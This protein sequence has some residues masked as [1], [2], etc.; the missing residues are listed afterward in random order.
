MRKSRFVVL[1]SF[2]LIAAML[3]PGCK[4][5]EKPIEI[6]TFPDVKLPSLAEYLYSG[7]EEQTVL[8]E[9]KEISAKSYVATAE[10]TVAAGDS[11]DSYNGALFGLRC[12][13]ATDGREDSGIWFAFCGGQGSVYV[14]DGVD[15]VL[16]TKYKFNTADGIVFKA[17]DLGNEITVYVNDTTVATVVFFTGRVV[18]RNHLG[19]IEG[20]IKPDNIAGGDKASGYFRAMSSVEG[21]EV[22]NYSVI[23]Q[24]SA[25]Y[26]PGKEVFAL[27]ET[28]PCVFEDE[29]ITHAGEGG[30]VTEQGVLFADYASVGKMFGF[31][32]SVSGDTYTLTRDNVTLKF[33]ANAHKININGKDYDFTTTYI[34]DGSLMIDV[35]LFASLMGYE[36][37]YDEAKKTHYI[38]ADEALLTAEK[39]TAIEERVKLYKDVIYNYE[40]VECDQTGVGVYEKTPAEERL[41]GI[42]YT[43]WCGATTEW[44]E[45][46][47]DTP[48]GGGYK[49]SDREVIYRHGIQLA[50][51]GIDFVF[52][53]WSNNTLY[54]PEKMNSYRADFRMIEES[55]DLLFEEWSKIPNAP[56]ICIFAGP[57]HDG[58]NSVKSGSHQSKVDQI[59]ENYVKKYPDLYFNYQ[60]KPLLMC[61]GATGTQYGPMPELYWPDD[62]R[63]TVRWLTGFVGQQGNLYNGV[64]MCSQKYWSWEERGTQTYTVSNGKV[65]A[66]TCSA[67]TRVQSTEGMPDYIA[68]AGRQNGDT[69]KKQFQRANDLGARI[70]LIVSWNEWIKAEQPSVEIS[71]DMEPS[72]TY[73]TFYYDLMR[74]QIR[75]FKSN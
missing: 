23:S 55:T 27:N 14:K 38:T 54:D 43:T 66:V 57:G 32:Y 40:D 17:E 42:A 72:E 37:Y 67:A 62:T 69:F 74:E 75:K 64:T 7:T 19:K 15:E 12:K 2:F 71:K 68:P 35:K 11:E 13:E 31:K 59:Y 4:P 41:V 73:G 70:V 60:G 20:E 53:D 28:V 46:T 45:N 16:S 6:V 58:I 21:T 51:A 24:V 49:S 52:V 9:G 18:I 48:L 36:N 56:K 39:K 10:M 5:A 29:K 30:V 44:G 25:G 65:E 34:K 50:E 63:F 33:T 1:L 22:E 3:L 61:Y 47:W 26:M 8:T